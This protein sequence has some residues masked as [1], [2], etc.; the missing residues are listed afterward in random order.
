MIVRDDPD[1]CGSQGRRSPAQAKTGGKVIPLLDRSWAW[2]VYRK[3]TTGYFY[4]K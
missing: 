4:H 2:L 3:P 1:A